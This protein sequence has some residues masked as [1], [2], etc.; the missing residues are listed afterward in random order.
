MNEEQTS[1]VAQTVKNLP[2]ML[3]TRVWSLGGEDPLEKGMATHSSILA[4]RIPWTEEPGGI[5][6]RES[7]RVRHNWEANTHTH[8]H[9]HTQVKCKH[10]ARP[11]GCR[12]DSGWDWSPPYKS[13]DRWLYEIQSHRAENKEE[14]CFYMGWGPGWVLSSVNWIGHGSPT[15]GMQCLIILDGA[16]VVIIEIKCTIN[17]MCLNHPQTNSPPTVKKL[18]SVKPVPG[19]KKVGHHRSR[20]QGSCAESML[21][22]LLLVFPGPSKGK[23]GF[24]RF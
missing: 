17:V 14:S 6:P 4:Y 7:Q 21:G 22:K 2:A 5:Q 19:A 11:W 20:W 13:D 8:T 24:P 3:E 23:P 12:V 1:L 10:Y 9:T 18:S 15:F 16:D